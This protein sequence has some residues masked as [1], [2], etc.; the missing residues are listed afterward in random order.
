M[1]TAMRTEDRHERRLL[2]PG[3]V[4]DDVDAAVVKLRRGL[5]ADAPQSFDRKR[6]EEVELAVGGDDQHSVG[7]CDAARDL[8]EELRAGDPDGDRQPDLARTPVPAVACAISSRRAREASQPSDVEERFVDRDALDEGRGVV[9]DLEHRLARLG[10]RGEAGRDLDQVRAHLPGLAAAHRGVDP[11]RLRLVA[12][13]EHD[14]A[15]DDDGLAPEP[16]D[17][18]AA[19]PTR[20]TSRGPRGGSWPRFAPNICSHTRDARMRRCPR[21]RSSSRSTPPWRLVTWRRWRR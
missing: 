17:R 9:E 19:R 21:S 18:R 3:D 8:R 16:R 4:G 6:M 12:R 11:E 14:P 5:D 1:P 15:A 2:E 7:L 10:V 20:R 13:G